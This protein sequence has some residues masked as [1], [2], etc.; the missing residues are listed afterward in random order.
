MKSNSWNNL[1]SPCCSKSTKIHRN[2]LKHW[3][4]SKVWRFFLIYLYPRAP[5]IKR[6]Q[7]DCNIYS[8]NEKGIWFL[9]KSLFFEVSCVIIA[10]FTYLWLSHKNPVTNNHQKNIPRLTDEAHWNFFALWSS[11]TFSVSRF[12]SVCQKIV[13]RSSKNLN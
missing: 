1:I 10:R 8:M 2:T 9:S 6:R 3:S 7:T 11:S 5:Y 13:S 12:A 4:V